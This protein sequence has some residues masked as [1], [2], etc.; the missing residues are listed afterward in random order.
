MRQKLFR[1]LGAAGATAALLLT[2]ACGGTSGTTAK[3]AGSDASSTAGGTTSITVG[4]IPDMNGGGFIAVADKLDLWKKNGVDVKVKSFTNGPTQVQAMASGDIDFGYIGPGAAWLPASG[5]ATVVTLDN[6]GFGDYVLAR[7]D[8]GIKTVADLKG[9]KVGVPEGTSGDMILQIALQ[10]AGLS[11]KDIQK[12][13][14]DPT[15]VV[16][17]FAS[18]QIDAAGIFAPQSSQMEQSVPG[19]LTLAQDKD[20]YPEKVFFGMWLARN[21]VV[22]QKPDA[23]VKF[24]K[25]FQEATDYR[26]KNTADAVKLTA[27]FTNA[28]EDKLKAQADVTQY[29]S[30]A[31]ISK[32]NSDGST[33]KWMQGL[34]DLFV[35]FGKLPSAAAPD[36]FVNTELFSK[37]AGS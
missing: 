34:Q 8:R 17:A 12:V 13:P 28:P 35:Q 20:F 4:Y 11:D 27:A 10:K 29:L 2:A 36:T 21:E 9:K 16:T 7:P 23:V 24:L 6:I 32:A 25:V 31:D 37:A 18:G 22:K 30:T 15:T 33:I 14:M 26:A 1:S 3:A 19:T 5:K